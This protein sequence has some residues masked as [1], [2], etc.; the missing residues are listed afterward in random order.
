MIRANVKGLGGAKRIEAQLREY[1][2]G[3]RAKTIQIIAAL[4]FAIKANLA[5]ELGAEK[6]EHFDVAM[7]PLGAGTSAYIVVAPA[8]EIG[9][10][11]M[12]GTE[13]HTI[14]GQSMPIGDGLFAN[15][16]SHPGQRAERER[17]EAAVRNAF[18]EVVGIMGVQ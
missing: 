18:A 14:V 9:T 1:E 17:I 7:T 2:M 11:I 10:Y 8:D 16:V 4:H 13:P 15:V 5:L 3:K 6:A 12:E